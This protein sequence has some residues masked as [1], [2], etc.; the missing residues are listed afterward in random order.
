MTPAAAERARARAAERQAA[1]GA[2]GR[3]KGGAS[4]VADSTLRH[5]LAQMETDYQ[6]AY[7]HFFPGETGSRVNNYN[8]FSQALYDSFGSGTSGQDGQGDQGGQN[9]GGDSGGG[10][11]GNNG[12]NNG[13]GDGGGSTNPNNGG[14]DSQP[15]PSGNSDDE[16]DNQFLVLGPLDQADPTRFT[17]QATRDFSGNFT[18]DTGAPLQLGSAVV[19][20]PR[21]TLLVPPGQQLL[22]TDLDGDQQLDYIL[23]VS[24]SV[25]SALIG[26][27]FNGGELQQWFSGA[28]LFD[29]VRSMAIFDFNE[30]GKNELAV[31]FVK[32]PNLVIYDIS[33]GG[34][35]YQKELTLP[36][37]PG[38]LVG[39]E[40]RKGSPTRYLQVFDNKLERSVIF[41]SRF[42]GA[43]SFSKPP[44]YKGTQQFDVTS[45]SGSNYRRYRFLRYEDRIVAL[46]IVDGEAEVM[47]NFSI[48][49]GF[50]LVLA[51]DYSGD[52]L[53]QVLFLP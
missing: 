48:R 49:A 42:P 15:P 8:P 30:D 38:L 17:F 18:L 11:S 25:G 32:N 35:A 2:A 12:G 41:S 5:E 33:D 6:A 53:Q 31:A 52:G 40:D 36:F 45:L 37:G 51:G 19:G 20:Y 4:A 39:T 16:L 44:T 1:A 9:G 3:A 14:G 13:G 22:T 7:S 27:R 26:Y 21:P 24:T 29:L 34:L 47:V 50:P 10:D 23:T 46:Q 28:F 43:Y